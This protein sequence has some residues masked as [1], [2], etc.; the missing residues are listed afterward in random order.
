MPCA[1]SS[2]AHVRSCITKY[3]R[4]TKGRELLMQYATYTE[5]REVLVQGRWRVRRA[6]ASFCSLQARR[7]WTVTSCSNPCVGMGVFDCG[8]AYVDYQSEHAVLVSSRAF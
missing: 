5:S 1:A 7:R 8:E 3:A 2:H 6:V 4:Y